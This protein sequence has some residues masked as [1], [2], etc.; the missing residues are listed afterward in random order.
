ME[1][2]G[3]ILHPTLVH[4]NG[5]GFPKATRISKNGNHP[6]FEGHRYGLQALKPCAEFILVAQKPYEGKPVECITSTGAGALWIDGSRVVTGDDSV[7]LFNHNTTVRWGNNGVPPG[8]KTKRTGEYSTQ[9]RW[10]PNVCLSHVAPSEHTPG[11]RALGVKRVRGTAPPGPN[12]GKS[13][14]FG[15]SDMEAGSYKAGFYENGY[16][17]PDGTEQVADWLCVDGCPVKALG[18]QSGERTSGGKNGAGN[19]SIWGGSDNRQGGYME[20]ST[21]T[22]ARFYPQAAWSYEA[23]EAV[24]E[25]LA[26][27]VPFRYQ[28]KAAKSERQAGLDDFYWRKDK[29]API[30]FVRISREEWEQLPEKQRAQGNIHPTQ[31]PIELCKFLATLLLPPPEY[32]PRRILIPFFGKGSEGAG[33]GLAGWEEIV[34]IEKEPDYCEAGRSRLAHW[35]KELQLGLSL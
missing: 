13:T 11:C 31:K 35:L 22:A 32:A 17:D 24:A 20:P 18:E 5:Q 33:A 12:S 34:G 21:G 10:P 25:R 27:V 2:A 8:V 16:A 3:L 1:D 30:G 9:G 28:A 4:L 19:V 6:E 29:T 15:N 7:P 23:A 14:Y 26:E